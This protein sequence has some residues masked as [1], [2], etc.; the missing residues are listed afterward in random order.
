MAA[1]H[2]F[3][4]ARERAVAI[5]NPC[6]HDASAGLARVALAE[7]DPAAALAFLHPVLEHRASGGELEG[8][9]NRMWIE[10]TCYEVMDRANDPRAGDWLTRAHAAL[11]KQSDAITDATLR[12]GFLHNISFNREIMAAWGKL[13]GSDKSP[14]SA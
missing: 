11:I 14:A 7:G 10:L 9:D 3:L 5:D 1:R 8:S 12:Q 6:Q 4:Q 13:E 2:A